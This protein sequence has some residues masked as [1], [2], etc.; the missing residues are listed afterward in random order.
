MDPNEARKSEKQ[1]NKEK[2]ALEKEA[3]AL[4]K[5]M[6]KLGKSGNSMDILVDLRIAPLSDSYHK[7][8]KELK[9]N[10]LEIENVQSK[11][12]GEELENFK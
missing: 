7:A 3:K 12:T 1:K 11:L 5:E 10:F 6:K 2:K 4:E 8:I 9:N